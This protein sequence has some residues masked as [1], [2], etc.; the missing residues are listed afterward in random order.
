MPL[1]QHIDQRT[2]YDIRLA[3]HK[4]ILAIQIVT[5][6][7]KNLHNAK[8]SAGLKFRCRIKAININCVWNADIL[9]VDMFW[10][11]KLNNNTVHIFPVIIF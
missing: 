10:Q 3:A 9:W 5:N 11:R 4:H 1:N 8:R 7:V 2:T 6:G